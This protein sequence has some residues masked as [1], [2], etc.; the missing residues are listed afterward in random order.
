[1][2]NPALIA[3][4]VAGGRTFS[5]W[6]SIEI[7]RRYNDAVSRMQLEVAEFV[8]SSQGW[9]SL[10]LMPG[11]PAQGYLAGQLAITGQ[12]S[13]R[14]AVY[15]K[16]THLVR[17]VVSSNTMPLTIST[18]NS[19]PGQYRG[20]TWLQLAQAVAGK[21]GVNVKLLSGTD[22]TFARVSET[23]GEMRFQ[24][25]ERLARMRNFYLRDDQNGNFVATQ[26][27]GGVVATLVEG[28]N[29]EAAEIIFRNNEYANPAKMIGANI[30]G[31]AS[32]VWGGQAC[33]ISATVTSP[34]M[35]ANV[36]E[37]IP[38]SEPCDQVDVQLGAMRVAAENLAQYV[39]GTITVFGWLLPNGSLWI[40]QVGNQ[41]TIYSPMLAPV[42]S[43]TLAIKGVVCRQNNETGTQTLIELCLPGALG[44]PG[45]ALSAP[46]AAAPAFPPELGIA[47]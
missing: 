1:M 42:Q 13:V 16:E 36:P 23:P 28:Q 7:A 37:T 24:F 6:Q 12:V 9:S 27:V 4:V 44:A 34:N 46:G 25:M 3:T 45:M 17:I 40:D 10:Q 5:A 8:D 38:A 26:G 18:V 30:G 31:S 2:P 39:T 35:P 47:Q 14:Q 11:K 41:V 15:N 33:D 20:Y 29:I 43:L 22:K 21:V 32:G 19:N